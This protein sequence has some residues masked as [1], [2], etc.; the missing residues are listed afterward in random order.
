MG[1][2]T[3]VTRFLSVS[4]GK[5]GLKL[6]KYSP[7]ILDGFGIVSMIGAVV[8]AGV[9]TA[10]RAEEV[11]D[12]HRRKMEEAEEAVAIAEEDGVDDYNEGL[13]KFLV[14][15][16]TAMDLVKVYWPT[17]ALTGISVTCFLSAHRIMKARYVGAVAAFN[18]VS[19]AFSGYRGRIREKYGEE[20]DR[21][22][23]YGEEKSEVTIYDLEPG[24][25]KPTKIVET[26]VDDTPPW[27]SPYAKVFDAS[28]DGWSS[29][30]TLSMI[31][32]KGQQELANNLLHTRGHVFLNEVYEMLGFAHTSVGAVVG[33]VDGIG[34]S[35]IDFGLYNTEVEATRRFVNGLENVIILDFNVDGVIYDKI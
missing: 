1:V 9:R 22:G 21:Y 6:C 34:D 35:F 17:I 28:C 25:K 2:L 29:N 24:K 12:N 8:S 23:L 33:W 26:H 14:Y 10:T 27:Y 18:A 20:G 15:K 32:L 5:T 16:E 30:P 3:N 7:E 31:F 4:A 11:L 13:E 19:E